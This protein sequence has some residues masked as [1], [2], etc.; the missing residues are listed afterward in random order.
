MGQKL[1]LKELEGVLLGKELK[2]NKTRVGRC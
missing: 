1:W 2:A